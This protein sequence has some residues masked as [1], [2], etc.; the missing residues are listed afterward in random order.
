MKNNNNNSC[1]SNTIKYRFKLFV[2]GNEPNSVQ[3]KEKLEKVSIK[4]LN[5]DYEI[6]IIDIL[7]DLNSA[8]EN[9]VLVT[10]M[11][12]ISLPTHETTIVGSLSDTDKLLNALQLI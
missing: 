8:L 6:K 2:A 7:K 3:A 12:I 5:N 4:Y 9:G 10:P 1:S 11:L